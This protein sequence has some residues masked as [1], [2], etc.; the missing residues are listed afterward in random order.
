MEFFTT[1]SY[2]EANENGV[3]KGYLSIP[4]RRLFFEKICFI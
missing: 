4:E 2:I 3:E 1:G